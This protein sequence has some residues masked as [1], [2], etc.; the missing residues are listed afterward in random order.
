[1][2]LAPTKP[3]LSIEAE[4]H[5]A[6]DYDERKFALWGSIPQ[7]HS[8]QPDSLLRQTNSLLGRNKFPA[9]FARE[10]AATHWNCFVN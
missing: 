8:E 6:M 9:P 5:N 4:E 3:T 1:M 7:N 10:Y 2:K